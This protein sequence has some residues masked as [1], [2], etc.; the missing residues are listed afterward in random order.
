MNT[1]RDIFSEADEAE[2]AAAAARLY[3]CDKAWLPEA[4]RHTLAKLRRLT[5]DASGAEYEL[6]IDLA[7]PLLPEDEPGWEVWL[8]K[9]GG[10]EERYGLSLSP[11]E[12]WLAAP[13][14]TSAPFASTTSSTTTT[15]I[16]LKL[17]TPISRLRLPV[18]N[19]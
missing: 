17:R 8:R 7:A 3:A 14:P 18:N 19:V 13:I 2:V 12:E 10:P 15:A 5:P 9:A 16:A 11:W 1:L 4:I 6:H